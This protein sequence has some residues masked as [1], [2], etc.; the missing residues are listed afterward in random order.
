VIL[1]VCPLLVSCIR[2]RSAYPLSKNSR[3]LLQTKS[4]QYFSMFT[5]NRPNPLIFSLLR[6]TPSHA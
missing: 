6:P 3:S 2:R 4:Q 1:S 5:Y